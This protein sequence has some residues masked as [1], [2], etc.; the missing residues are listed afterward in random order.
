MEE[1]G[2]KAETVEKAVIM[3]AEMGEK[4][5]ITLEILTMV[6]AIPLGIPLQYWH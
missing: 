3:M 4:A 1:V 2:V 6:R 5:V